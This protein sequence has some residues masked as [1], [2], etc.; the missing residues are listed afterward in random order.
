MRW[1]DYQRQAKRRRRPINQSKKV[2]YEDNAT[3]EYEEYE[4]VEDIESIKNPEPDN[5]LAYENNRPQ[6]NYKDYGYHKKFQKYGYKDPNEVYEE[7]EHY[8]EPVNN[9]KDADLVD[10]I[11]KLFKGDNKMVKDIIDTLQETGILENFREPISLINRV[12]GPLL[13]GNEGQSNKVPMWAYNKAN[14]HIKRMQRENANKQLHS[15]MY[16]IILKQVKD[17]LV[18]SYGSRIKSNMPVLFED[19]DE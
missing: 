9:S 7:E 1:F 11:E 14:R 16:N 12:Y 17:L 4:I 18:N 13:D 10:T 2:D 6:Y 8:S 5:K 3:N 19:D 15:E